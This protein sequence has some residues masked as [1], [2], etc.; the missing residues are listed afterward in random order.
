VL[1]G[2]TPASPV[3]QQLRDAALAQPEAAAGQVGGAVLNLENNL[4][5]YSPT[6]KPVALYWVGRA[7]VAAADERTREEGMLQLLRIAAVY[8][9]QHPELAAAG[10]Y[11]TMEAMTKANQPTQTAAV[12]KELLDRYGQTYYAGVA[13]GQGGGE[14]R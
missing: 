4:E 11:H 14:K 8:G 2:F 3:I 5:S 10:L 13:K 6:A 7:K 12:R 1:T 9:D